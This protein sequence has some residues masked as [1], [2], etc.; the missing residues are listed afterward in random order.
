[1]VII[2]TIQEPQMSQNNGTY[3]NTFML[4]IDGYSFDSIFQLQKKI[5]P[6]VIPTR[7]VR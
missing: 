4:I 1:M 7:N 6:V 2:L 3:I 5:I